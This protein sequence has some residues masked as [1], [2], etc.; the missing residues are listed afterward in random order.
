MAVICS[1]H[2]RI[3]PQSRSE[4]CTRSSEK[5]KSCTQSWALADALQLFRFYLQNFSSFFFFFFLKSLEFKHL[6]RV[7]KLIRPGESVDIVGW[8]FFNSLSNNVRRNQW[9]F[10]HL[11]TLD[12][13]LSGPPWFKSWHLY[14]WGL[15]R[16]KAQRYVQQIMQPS[17]WQL[18]T[19]S[20]SATT[21]A[22]WTLSP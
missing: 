9:S 1:L 20:F 11:E 22:Q 10:Q 17:P 12:A 3:I 5:I 4:P 13:D 14:V 6:H 16:C 21:V 18:K 19:F 7:V 2:P 15:Y 8:F